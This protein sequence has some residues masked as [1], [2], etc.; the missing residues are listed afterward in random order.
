MEN[1]HLYCQTPKFSCWLGPYFINMP[2]W[3]H[4]EFL[5]IKRPATKVN[6][7][8]FQ[9]FLTFKFPNH[10]RWCSSCLFP[11]EASNSLFKVIIFLSSSSLNHWIF[12]LLPGLQDYYAWDFDYIII[13]SWYPGFSYNLHVI[14]LTKRHR[15]LYWLSVSI[16]SD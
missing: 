2:A 3:M 10:W 13:D 5:R 6:V 15:I 4:Y 12:I 9:V 14:H 16:L 7:F 8:V 11:R 1:S